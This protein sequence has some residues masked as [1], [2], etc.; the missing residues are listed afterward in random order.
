MKWTAGKTRQ[1]SPAVWWPVLSSYAAHEP[2]KNLYYTVYVHIKPEGEPGVAD[3]ELPDYA[4][5]V[6]FQ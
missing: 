5:H 3:P 6:S 1:I 2:F 4:S